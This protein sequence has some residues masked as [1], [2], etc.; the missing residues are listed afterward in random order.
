MNRQEI[1]NKL[2]EVFAEVFFDDTIKISDETT[3]NDIE[4]WDSLMHM[5]LISNVEDCFSIEFN[6]G[7]INSFKN[8]GEMI[9]SIERHLG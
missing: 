9:D 5:T 6:M 2:N 3:A 7:E 4:A 8:V 1:T